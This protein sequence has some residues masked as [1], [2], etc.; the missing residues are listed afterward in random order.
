MGQDP[1]PDP[2]AMEV[3]QLQMAEAQLEGLFLP[4]RPPLKLRMV[5]QAFLGPGLFQQP[6]LLHTDI[7]S[8]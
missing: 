8:F 5:E 7:Q 1:S 6:L 2:P 3:E 4:T